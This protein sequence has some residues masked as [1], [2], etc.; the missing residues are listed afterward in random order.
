MFLGHLN[1][2]GVSHDYLRRALEFQARKGKPA[3]SDDYYCDAHELAAMVRGQ[4][5]KLPGRLDAVPDAC[6]KD[7][8]SIGKGKT[9]ANVAVINIEELFSK[10]AQ[11]AKPAL[12]MLA[13]I[14]Y[15]DLQHPGEPHDAKALDKA[16]AVIEKKPEHLGYFLIGGF[17]RELKER[18]NLTAGFIPY[19]HPRAEKRVEDFLFNSMPRAGD[20][21]LL[22]CFADTMYKTPSGEWHT[23][24]NERQVTQ[25]L[26]LAVA[27]GIV[28]EQ[29]LHT[30]GVM[31]G[32]R[33]HE[34]PSLVEQLKAEGV[35]PIFDKPVRQAQARVSR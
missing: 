21:N 27:R 29:S 14:N 18:Y 3:V 12:K 5:E 24:H 13:A 30:S 25:F 11:F 20:S 35:T 34:L 23:Y 7:V 2:E 32:A 9:P 15:L 28:D 22:F 31:F 16:M 10:K 6:W 4:F 8:S 33:Y 1:S 17:I 26:A 19:H